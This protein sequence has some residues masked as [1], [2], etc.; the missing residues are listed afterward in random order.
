LTGPATTTVPPSTTTSTTTAPLPPLGELAGIFPQGKG[1]GQVKPSEFYNG[2]VR[3][4]LVRNIVWQ[5]WGGP[6]AVG[7]GV[8]ENVAPNQDVAQGTEE[9]ATVV[10]FKLGSCV[11]NYMYEA[12]EWHFPQHGQ[13]FNPNQY[14]DFCT[15]A[16]MTSIATAPT[17][18]PGQVKAGDGLFIGG[19]SG[20]AAIGV[21]LTNE[22]PGPCG[23]DHGKLPRLDH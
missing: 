13:R 12:I 10:A 11:G 7:S 20:E 5:S 16:Y 21:T 22:G 3:A 17:C 18:R 19:A 15:G 8:A 23:N 2:N 14:E 1:F 6:K 9:P 4:G